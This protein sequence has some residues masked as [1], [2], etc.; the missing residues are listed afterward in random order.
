LILGISRDP[1]SAAMGWLRLDRASAAMLEA[2]G[3]SAH[4][5]VGCTRAQGLK[6]I[7]LATLRTWLRDDSEDMAQTMAALDRA[8]RQ[9]ERL[10]RLVPGRWRAPS[11]AASE[12][13][14]DPA[15]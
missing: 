9:A 8:L 2:A 13:A 10:L 14:P 3:I 15:V 6:A 5:L 12:P 11:P 4:G 7:Y 1:G